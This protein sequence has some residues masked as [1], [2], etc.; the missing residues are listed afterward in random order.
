MVKWGNL[1][2]R[3]SAY[4]AVSEKLG[5]PLNYGLQGMVEVLNHGMEWG[6]IFSHKAGLPWRG[7]SNNT[8]ELTNARR[9]ISWFL[10]T[11]ESGYR[12]T[13]TNIGGWCHFWTIHEDT[14]TTLNGQITSGLS[15]IRSFML[16]CEVS[17]MFTCRNSDNPPW[18]QL[19]SEH[20]K[21]PTIYP[22]ELWKWNTEFRGSLKWLFQYEVLVWWLGLFG[23][24]PSTPI[25]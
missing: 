17:L 12:E 9:G 24:Y 10:V 20:W 25:T 5:L 4:M 8:W 22:V 6:S 13:A 15:A 21:F 3:K 23:T 14:A 1:V 16:E 19:Q 7:L 11:M 2:C 18:T